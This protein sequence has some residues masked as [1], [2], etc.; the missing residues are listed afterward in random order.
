MRIYGSTVGW[1]H[2]GTWPNRGTLNFVIRVVD[3]WIRSGRLI[4]FPK[5]SFGWV[6]GTAYRVVL[7]DLGD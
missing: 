3:D 2:L 5:S 7:R 4:R 1:G 6:P